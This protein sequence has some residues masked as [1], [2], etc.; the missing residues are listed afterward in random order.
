[1]LFHILCLICDTSYREVSKQ[2]SLMFQDN[3][4]GTTVLIIRYGAG[5]ELMGK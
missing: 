2:P 4:D 5:V 1:M 3:A